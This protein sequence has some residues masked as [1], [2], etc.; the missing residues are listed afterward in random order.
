MI[1]SARRY[2]FNDDKTNKVV[3]GVSLT[4]LTPDVDQ[5]PDRRGMSPLT[6]SAPLDVWSSLGALPGVY[7]LDLKQ[8]PGKNGRPTLTCVGAAFVSAVDLARGLV[9]TTSGVS[10]SSNG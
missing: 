5:E 4:Y 1:L 10:V 7:K 2:Q 3:E 8:R 6:I 9:V